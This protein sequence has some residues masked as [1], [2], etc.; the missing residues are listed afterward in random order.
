[1]LFPKHTPVRLKGKAVGEL[2]QQCFE[3]DHFRCVLC[4]SQY[5]LQMDHIKSRGLGGGDT[6]DNVQ[7][8]CGGPNSCHAKKHVRIL[9]G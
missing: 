2:R 1:M 9:R 5:N 8:L 6:L 4:G 7:T 3:R